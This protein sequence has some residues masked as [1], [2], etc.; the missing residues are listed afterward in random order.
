MRP[1]RS[2]FSKRGGLRP[3]AFTTPDEPFKPSKV[4]EDEGA[5]LDLPSSQ[6]ETEPEPISA[7]AASVKQNTDLIFLDE[8]T[9]ERIAV[10]PADYGFRSGSGRL[11]QSS[12]GAVPESAWGLAMQNFRKELLAL[13]RSIRYDEYRQISDRQ[14]AAGA[15]PLKLTSMAVGGFV[16]QKLAVL[17]EWLEN[18]DL[19]KEL[20]LPKDA[21][22]PKL[23]PEQAEILDKV[24]HL[25][26][27]DEKVALREKRREAEEGRVEAS[28][29]IYVAYSSLC[30]ILD[31]IYAGRPIQRFWFLE[32]VARMPYFSYISMLHLYESLGWWR[33][34]A[35]IRKVHFAEEWNELHHLQIM[36]AL[37]GDIFW[38]DRFLAEH[39]AVFYYWT[40]VVMY[41]I[42]PSASYSFSELVEH[43]AEDTYAE[44]AEQNEALLKTIPPPLVALNYYKA[45]D[46]Y[47]FDQLQTGYGSKTPRRPSCSTLFD[48]FVNIRDDEH[49]HVKTMAACKDGSITKDLAAGEEARSIAA[50]KQVRV[51]KVY[52]AYNTSSSSSSMSSVETESTDK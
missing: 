49:E 11:Y 21:R 8:N 26:L 23:T 1:G 7:A 40:I 3:T 12:Y 38:V 45:G 48:V 25:T 27:D 20:H 10:M 51:L 42:S 35:E 44:F 47:L 14:M 46:L 4:R 2:S 13:R 29:P 37:G 50:G 33:A 24:R 31:V 30:W 39:A 15:G 18:Q 41:L 19:I 6:T 32:T 22:D 5:T 34:G 28:W 17:D 52:D 16:R 36:E 43:H 9:G